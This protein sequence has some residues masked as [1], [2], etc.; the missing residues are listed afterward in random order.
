MRAGGNLSNFDNYCAHG[1]QILEQCLT[2]FNEE[3]LYLLG[4]V[5]DLI[6]IFKIGCGKSGCTFQVHISKIIFVY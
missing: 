2:L 5:D 3:P 1:I 6:Y 4:W